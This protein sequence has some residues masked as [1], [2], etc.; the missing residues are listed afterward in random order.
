M[1]PRDELLKVG[2]KSIIRVC[3]VIDRHCDGYQAYVMAVKLCLISTFVE[4]DELRNK[5]GVLMEMFPLRF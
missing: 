5:E 1:A 2:N 4:S 3:V